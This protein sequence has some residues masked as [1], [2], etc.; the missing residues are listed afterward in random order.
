LAEQGLDEEAIEDSSDTSLTYKRQKTNAG[1]IEK[2]LVPKNSRR[3]LM[4]EMNEQ[5]ESENLIIE[6][7]T[8][9]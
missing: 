5:R 1:S 2:Y 7:G 4:A 9:S 6:G 3:N 8:E